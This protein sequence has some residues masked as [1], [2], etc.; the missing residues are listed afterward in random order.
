MSK[1]DEMI[2]KVLDLAGK[3][4]NNVYLSAISQG[5]MQTLPVLMIGSIALLL[6]VLP[7]NAWS[8]FI[9]STGIKTYLL[10]ASTLTTSLI[11]LYSTFC[12]GYQFATLKN[13]EGL[14]SG[15]V[16]IFFF[17]MLTPLKEGALDTSWLSA[18]GLF[19]AM[20]ASLVASR[21]YILC[22]DKNLTIHMP[23]GVPPFVSKTFTSLF[24]AIIV[25]VIAIV[26]SLAFGK[27]SYGSFAQ[28]IYSVVAK[29]L[30]G[31][32]GSIWSLVFI[33]L[34]QMILWFFGIHGS[35]VVGSFVT[36]LYL[37]LDTMNMD[38][39][40]A[41]ATNSELPN[42]LGKSFY[43]LFAGIGGAG[44][45]LSLLIVMLLI[46]KS[47]KNKAL[48]KLSIV[49]GFFTINEP[50]VFGYPMIL[51][52]IMAIPFILTPLV[53]LLVAY[54]A[55]VTGI[56]PKLSGVQVPFGMPV[57]VNG[58]IA[59]GWKVAVLQV[60]VILIGVV[61]YLPFF[62]LSDRKDYQS[63]MEASGN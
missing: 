30:E 35:L 15:V 36:A 19:T 16:S 20:I 9:T 42:I 2:A 26:V 8:N 43:G 39:L 4:Q 61:I 6:A 45:T 49:P 27:T 53:Q 3:V 51:N 62:K 38:A 28:F 17:L 32:T 50:V 1:K 18:Q 60:V 31:L 23:D 22:I 48:S 41:G 7:I 63:E 58:F 21:L 11:A 10:A 52:P 47:Q 34:I 46:S 57:I 33:V 12:I 29:P 37:P 5:L 44:G 14:P 40:A 24:P 55:T 13:H 56:V 25:G 54:G 59:G